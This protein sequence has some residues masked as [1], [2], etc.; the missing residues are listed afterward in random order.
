MLRLPYLERNLRVDLVQ[1]GW[2][3]DPAHL[4]Q[5]RW[6]NCFFFA[7]SVPLV[8]D[9]LHDR[10]DPDSGLVVIVE[11]IEDLVKVVLVVDCM[12]LDSWVAY[13]SAGGHVLVTLV[14]LGHPLGVSLV[15]QETLFYLD[16]P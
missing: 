1:E 12:R 3:F 11:M 9:P 8:V 4:W 14:F 7:G 6:R 5:Q 10:M 2:L 16:Q 13:R 15:G